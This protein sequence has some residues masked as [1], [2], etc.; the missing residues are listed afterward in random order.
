MIRK[1]A[2]ALLD[3]D[4]GDVDVKMADIAQACAI[5]HIMRAFHGDEG[6]K[7]FSRGGGASLSGIVAVH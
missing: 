1:T 3:E 2:E 4:G 6:Q 5:T 7:S